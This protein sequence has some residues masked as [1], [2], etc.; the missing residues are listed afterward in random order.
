VPPDLP[1]Y[2]VGGL[3]GEGGMGR[4]FEATRSWDGLHVALKVLRPEVRSAAARRTL[5]NEALATAHLAHPNLVAILD[6]GEHP[7][8]G[9]FLV[10]ELV[11]GTSLDAALAE[12]AHVDDGI[13]ALVAVLE[14]LTVA[15]AGGVVHGDLKPS[16]VLLTT[17]GFVKVCDFGVAQSLGPR[18]DGTGRRIRAGT[19][20]YMA[21]EQFETEVDLDPRSDLYAVGAMLYQVITGLL[22]HRNTESIEGILE[23]K[24]RGVPRPRFDRLGRAIPPGIAELVVSLTE[25]ELRLRPRFAAEALETLR[26]AAT[27]LRQSPSHVAPI[28]GAPRTTA[29][30]S[31]RSRE[32]GTEL[33]PTRAMTSERGVAR[34]AS[35]DAFPHSAVHDAAS[36]PEIDLDMP[37]FLPASHLPGTA[38]I[39]VKPPALVGRTHEIAAIRGAIRDAV[40]QRGVRAIVFEGEEGVGKSRLAEWGLAECERTGAMEGVAA[41]SALEGGAARGLRGLVARL[42]APASVRPGESARQTLLW[43]QQRGLGADV[44]VDALASWLSTPTQDDAVDAHTAASLAA[45]ALRAYARRRPLYLWLDDVLWASDGIFE[46]AERLLTSD[47]GP[48]VIVMTCND[49]A[50]SEPRGALRHAAL[51]SRD[52]VKRFALARLDALSRAALLRGTAPLSRA[53]AEHAGEL[54]TTPLVLVQLVGDWLD[55][56]LLVSTSA[57]LVASVPMSALFDAHTPSDV[58]RHR[59]L[60]LLKAVREAAPVLYATAILGPWC[61]SRALRLVG[62]A[63]DIHEESIDLVLEEALVRG[64]VRNDGGDTYRLSH[65]VFRVEL[66]RAAAVDTSYKRIC[67]AVAQSLLDVHGRERP[68]VRA[69]AAVWL[70]DAGQRSEAI[71][72]LLEASDQMARGGDLA[73]ASRQV[74]LARRWLE[75]D[76]HGDDSPCC[77]QLVYV[78]ARVAYF[79]LEYPRAL[80]HARDATRRLARRGGSSDALLRARNLELRIL[81]YADRIGECEALMVEVQ[82]D[83]GHLPSTGSYAGVHHL[84]LA[85]DLRVL[86]GDLRGARDL[87]RSATRSFDHGDR[88]HRSMLLCDLAAAEAAVGGHDEA[89]QAIAQV[90]DDRSQLDVYQLAALRERD[91]AVALAAGERR[92]RAFY[93]ERVADELARGDRWRLTYFRIVLALFDVRFDQPSFRQ[94]VAEAIDS[95]VTIPHDE[96]LSHAFL[97]AMAAHLHDRG[98]EEI[99]T[100]ID[101]LVTERR[102]IGLGGASRRGAIPA[103]AGSVSRTK[104][105]S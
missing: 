42:L 26:V 61:S 29:R 62:G 38:F 23:E 27:V 49:A 25:P 44:D 98:E 8:L 47:E 87:L 21:P 101:D 69:Y 70:R 59:A 64:V 91:H 67:S 46:L 89:R 37:E 51:T 104:P 41:R 97:I 71:T 75:E 39:H 55:R 99:A 103:G 45:G 11:V 54:D 65:Q 34:R 50:M 14:G 35:G 58:F 7:E 78:E 102:R 73:A 43:L 74:A 86:R 2:T 20:Q 31:V 57:G 32:A 36:E 5:I 28:S 82:R 105:S 40:K 16:N 33:L 17:S 68:D 79:S 12:G 90:R 66:I 10:Q 85:A 13:A 30:P 9:V 83:F 63:L 81:F 3:L 77:D 84:H 15:H 92:P 88:W 53:L 24:R 93:A 95:F 100:R 4:V 18:K 60:G 6:V 76:R 52:V 48:I 96:A 80:E 94:T 22:P 56:G 1:G 19:P 72:I